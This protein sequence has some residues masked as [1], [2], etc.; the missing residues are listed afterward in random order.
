[1]AVYTPRPGSIRNEQSSY[2]CRVADGVFRLPTQ[3]CTLPF[4]PS[5][6]F[7]VRKR[8]S[9]SS[10]PRLYS[11]WLLWSLLPLE[12]VSS[13]KYC[14]IGSSLYPYSFQHRSAL[15]PTSHMTAF[16]SFPYLQFAANP[17]TF[18]VVKNLR[19]HSPSL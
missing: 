18:V 10:D 1:M 4:A 12:I 7:V 3:K 13:L 14:R 16:S 9:G 8:H 6:Q 15:T 11:G 5:P 2:R 19:L 17:C